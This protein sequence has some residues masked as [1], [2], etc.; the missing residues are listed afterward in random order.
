MRIAG[1]TNGVNVNAI[2]DDLLVEPILGTAIL[3]GVPVTVEGV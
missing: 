1:A 2:T 3:N